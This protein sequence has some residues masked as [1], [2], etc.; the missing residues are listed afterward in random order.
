MKTFRMATLLAV[1]E[2]HCIFTMNSMAALVLTNVASFNSTNGERPLALIQATDG[3]FYGTTSHGGAAEKGTV[4]KMTP[5]G[6]LD[7]LISFD[8]LT[9][10]FPGVLLQAAD[11][12]F[13]GTTFGGGP[14]LTGVDYGAVFQL[15]PQGSFTN[16][17]YFDCTN[18]CGPTGLIQARDGN[19]YGITAYG[20]NSDYGIVFKIDT[21][22]IYS[23]VVQFNGTNGAIPIALIQGWDGNFYGTTQ[24]GY[25]CLGTVFKMTPNG[26][27]TT[28]ATFNGT[29]GASPATP[30]ALVQAPDG[31]LIGVTPYGG[32][33]YTGPSTSGLGTIYKIDTN[34]NFINLVMFDGTNGSSPSVLT[35]G[36]DSNLYGA[37]SDA[38]FKLTRSGW[39]TRLA[40]LNTNTGFSPEAS[41]IQARDGNFYG[42]ATSGGIYGPGSGINGYGTIFRLSVPLAPVLQLPTQMGSLVNLSWSA[43]AGQNYQVQFISDLGSTNWINLGGPTVA[44]NGVMSA[45]EA[46]GPD[47]QRFYRIE[48][49]P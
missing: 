37:T 34:L 47:A 12:N 39:F 40:S 14:Y 2:V 16:L 22:G 42:T 10:Y 29:N 3:N 4:F 30:Y 17:H 15:T 36:S 1:T 11:A 25:Q 5:D 35:W 27:L 6:T 21:N 26:Q 46:V 38:I 45:T 41:F 49:L 7:V 19:F 20:G 8:G 44:T 9:N 32:N 48:V 28:L 43:V 13:Y 18:G 31:S 33:G 23:V 24:F